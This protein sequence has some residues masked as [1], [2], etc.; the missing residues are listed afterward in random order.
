MSM[1][2]S[3]PPVPA[4]PMAADISVLVSVIVSADSAPTWNVTV[5]AFSSLMPLNSVLLVMSEISLPSCWTS[6]EMASLSPALEGAVGVLDLE[7]TDA[8]KHRVH[9]VERALTGLHQRDGV[10]RV[11]LRLR[12]TTDLTAHLLGDGEAGGVVG[13]TVH[14][15]ARGQLL[16]RLGRLGSG[17]R[18]IAMG[19]EGLDVVLDTKTH[20]DG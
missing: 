7:I 1:T 8:L 15:I 9:L 17:G 14:A 2:P 16:H 19:V 13:G 20:W 10:L 11:A 4:E 6:E 18:E 5:P 12:E 3:R